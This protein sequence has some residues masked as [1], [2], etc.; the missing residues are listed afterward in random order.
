V[1]VTKVVTKDSGDQFVVL[2][3]VLK[4]PLVDP[5]ATSAEVLAVAIVESVR[6]A[7]SDDVGI[8]IVENVKMRVDDVVMISV[9]DSAE[10]N[11]VI[12]EELEIVAVADEFV[13][14][15]VL[16]LSPHMTCGAG[17]GPDVTGLQP[18][19]WLSKPR[20]GSLLSG[21]C[22]RQSRGKLTSSLAARAGHADTTP[23][24][25]T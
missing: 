4:N 6:G 18:G 17:S 20:T 7:I 25:S 12:E 14:S 3:R 22:G 13:A 19:S 10:T 11:G 21:G 16:L 24:L 5:A 1:I 2:C 23:P 9:D 8:S 15:G